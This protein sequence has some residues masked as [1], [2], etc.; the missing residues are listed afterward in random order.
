MYVS[1]SFVPYV[2]H[3]LRFYN[4]NIFLQALIVS[5]AFKLQSLPLNHNDFTIW[6]LTLTAMNGVGFFNSNGIAGASQPHKHL[7]VVPNDVLWHLRGK[8]AAYV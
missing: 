8:D 4:T 6:Y 3:L 7:Q 1:I 5:N 2:W